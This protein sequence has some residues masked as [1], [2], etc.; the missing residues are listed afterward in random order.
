MRRTLEQ[1]LEEWRDLERLIR[2]PEQRDDAT[3]QRLRSD[4][5]R[6]RDE[7][8]RMTSLRRAKLDGRSG[9]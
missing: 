6:L 5:A 8:Q 3:E 2:S 7:Y 4:I 9:D 1:V